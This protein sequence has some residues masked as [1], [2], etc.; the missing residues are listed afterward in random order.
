MQHLLPVER[1]R[2]Q[3]CNRRGQ[4]DIRDYMLQLSIGL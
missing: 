1:S 3:A 4:A 2:E